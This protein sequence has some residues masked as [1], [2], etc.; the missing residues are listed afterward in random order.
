MRQNQQIYNYMK[1]AYLYVRVRTN[2]K[3]QITPYQ[4]SGTDYWS[5]VNITIS[6]SKEF[7]A[8]ISLQRISIDQNGTN[9]FSEIKK[10]SSGEDKN[11]LFIKWDQFS[12]NIEYAY[13]TKIDTAP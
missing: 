10:K 1:S 11:K 13:D 12:R 2:K 3:E 9:Y 8:K 7:I 6:K 4:S 5:I